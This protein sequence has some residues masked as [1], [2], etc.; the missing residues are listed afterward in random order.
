MCVCAGVLICRMVR[1]RCSRWWDTRRNRWRQQCSSWQDWQSDRCCFRLAKICCS[2]CHQGTDLQA[3]V[4]QGM[5]RAPGAVPWPSLLI[6][7]GS[8]QLAEARHGGV[9]AVH[10]SLAGWLARTSRQLLWVGFP[11]VASRQLGCSWQRRVVHCGWS[12]PLLRY[13]CKP[14]VRSLACTSTGLPS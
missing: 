3:A 2:S 5:M 13:C 1:R 7:V 12:R 6:A 9:V 14:R 4:L 10:V 8:C 11:P